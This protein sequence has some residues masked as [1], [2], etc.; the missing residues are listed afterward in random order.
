MTRKLYDENAYLTQ[1]SATVL[2][3][4]PV[5]DGFAVVLDQTAFFPEG[6]GQEADCGKLAGQDVLDVQIADGIVRHYVGKPLVVGERVE[7]LLN[8]EIRLSRMRQHTGEH[9]LS[10]VVHEMTGYDNVGFHMGSEGITV[11]FS[12]VLTEEQLC[13][14]VATANRIVMENRPVKAWYPTENELKKLS[15]RRASEISFLLR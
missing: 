2:S 10:G 11:D 5:E 9:I 7:G 13:T 8:W 1:F 4:M 15:Y 6:G 3:C 12:G 14:A